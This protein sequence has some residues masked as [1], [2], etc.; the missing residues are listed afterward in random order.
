[1]CVAVAVAVA[2][3]SRRSALSRS[4]YIVLCAHTHTA[5]GYFKQIHFL[6]IISRVCALSAPADS[7]HCFSCAR[8][9]THTPFRRRRQVITAAHSHTHTYLHVSSVVVAARGDK[10]ETAM[11]EFC[12]SNRRRGHAQSSVQYAH[13]DA[14]A[15]TTTL[16]IF[17]RSNLNGI[18][19]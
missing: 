9:H 15:Y 3:V 13:E 7:C 10:R 17:V 1:M 18:A 8:A 16:F 2:V 4:G 12:A 14:R 5:G 6:T 19:Q 11:C